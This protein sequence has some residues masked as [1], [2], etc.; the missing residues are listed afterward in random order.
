[1]KT[2]LLFISVCLMLYQTVLSDSGKILAQAAT[3]DT[4]SWSWEVSSTVSTYTKTCTLAFS[5][6]LLVDWG[7]GKREWIP[8]SLSTKAL[9]HVYTTQ[10]NFVCSAFG[11]GITYF[12]ADS[13]RVLTLDTHAAPLLDYLSCTS[14]QL[15]TLNLSKNMLLVS[16]YCGSNNLTDLS[17]ANNTKIQTLT[18]SD[19]KF[20]S[21]DLLNL[22]ELKKVTCHTNPLTEIKICS[23]G[24]LSY[25]S[26]LNC[27]LSAG[28]LDAIFTSLPALLIV[29]ASKN[30]YISNNPGLAGSQI[31]IAVNKNWLADVTVTKSSF[32]IPSVSYRTGDSVRIDICLNNPIPA[33]AFELDLVLPEGFILDTLRSTLTNAR[34]GSHTL[35]ISKTSALQYKFLAFSMKNKE[36]FA[37]N[38]GSVLQL[39]MKVPT[40]IKTY[41]IDIKNA[42]L[43]D[44][45]T[46][47]LDLSV[48]DGALTVTS[49]EIKGDAN[50]DDRVDVTDIVY[51]V[52][53]IN[54]HSSAGFNA[55]MSDIDGNGLW[56]IADITKMV[57]IINSQNIGPQ[58]SSH[59]RS[60]AT[61]EDYLSL[62]NY[63][64][65]PLG[66]HLYF[67]Q[68]EKDSTCLN[69]CLDNVE[70]VQALQVD[71]VLP[72]GFSFKT[73]ESEPTMIRS[74]EHLF[75]FSK[76]SDTENRYRL[77][78]YS[79]KSD[80]VFTGNSGVIASL[81]LD[82]KDNMP[83]DTYPVLMDQ[84]VMTGLDKTPI[85]GLTYDLGLK[86]GTPAEVVEPIIIGSSGSGNIWVRGSALLGVSVYDVAGKKLIEKDLKESDFFETKLPF[87]M[88]IVN[89]RSKSMTQCIKKVCVQ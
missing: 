12:K 70:A 50:G 67:R 56:N 32:Y 38:S 13:R 26:C 89:V 80:A 3:S 60:Q 45:L 85:N 65:A 59:S 51:L 52:A 22:L 77:L 6:S 88:Y 47:L 43:I 64:S 61:T 41:T 49:A 81:S 76:I 2:H 39:Y 71:I 16:L 24:G 84:S 42:L 36:I 55:L 46:N 53:Y 79:L 15:S 37:G 48:T 31:S 4:I 66:N 82:V 17:L 11:K 63:S 57:V 87:G 27:N 28:A 25:L 58:A 54:G 14:N 20:T 83:L 29:P 33:I 74:A 18:C 10:A 78:F 23:T 9:T 19:N 1:M 62:Y 7:D 72:E 8:D 21:L 69:L 75:S 73:N 40:D 30:L 35:S 68:S 34:K 5:D 44:T 86:I